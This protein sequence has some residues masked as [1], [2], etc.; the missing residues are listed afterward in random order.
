MTATL[1]A[2]EILNPFTILVDA[3]ENAR[4]W[5]AG[6]HQDAGDGGGRLVVPLE[7][8]TLNTG[9]YTIAGDDPTGVPWAS[10]V[11]VE[12]KSF[13]D[14]ISTIA[15]ER[16]RFEA[17]HARMASMEFAAVVIEAT[18]KE[19]MLRPHRSSINRKS[20]YRTWLSWQMQFGVPWVTLGDR[21][22][23]EVTTFRILEKFWRRKQRV[24]Q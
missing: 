3:R 24:C 9:D 17:E 7:Y 4:Y 14:L 20:V 6:L 18:W 11:C 12:R 15:G 22:L 19:I 1:A 8:A 21:G 13:E 23:A 16:E 10:L 5:F 2:D